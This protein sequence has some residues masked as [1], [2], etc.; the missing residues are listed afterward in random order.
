MDANGVYDVLSQDLSGRDPTQAAGMLSGF[1]ISLTLTAVL[2]AGVYYGVV[3]ETGAKATIPGLLIAIAI[4][5]LVC[6]LAGGVLGNKV[7]VADDCWRAARYGGC[8]D[9]GSDALAGGCITLVVQFLGGGLYQSARFLFSGPPISS[10]RLR[11]AAGVLTALLQTPSC[12]Q[13]Q[14]TWALE[15]A[16]ARVDSRQLD[17]AINLLKAGGYVQGDAM[18]WS[19]AS[20]KEHLF[21]VR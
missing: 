1:L 16:D 2:G 3:L 8:T 4:T 15:A 5:V 14:L 9:V 17:D 13:Q 7:G 12:D 19:I 10:Q 18:G 20:A 21:H 6:Y 11:V